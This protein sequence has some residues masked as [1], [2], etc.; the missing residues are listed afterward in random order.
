MAQRLSRRKIASYY[1]DELLA[2]N[3]KVVTE[4]A[5]FLLQSRRTNELELIV[6]DVE[7]AL[8]HRGVVVA[9]IASSRALTSGATAAITTFLSDKTR[10]TDIRLRTSV[11]PSLLG[12][13]RIRVPGQELDTTLSRKLSLLKA[14]K[15]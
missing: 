12:G 4:L 11:D 15:V 2:G 6:R 7:E 9:D 1:A 5:A 14:S 3:K 8:A 13:V 10:A